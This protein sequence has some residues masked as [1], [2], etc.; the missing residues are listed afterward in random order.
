[1]TKK[2]FTG[3]SCLH[4]VLDTNILYDEGAGDE[5]FS[6]A[7]TKVISNEAYKGLNIRWT[8]P[9]MVQ[10]ER[11]YHLRE[12]AKHIIA[13]ANK[14]LPSVLSG[15]WVCDAE[16]V[17]A[18]IASH[19]QSAIEK[20]GVTVRDCDPSKVDWMRIME[21]S[22][23]RLPPFDP[24]AEAEKG[25]KDAVVAETFMQICEEMR[26]FVH[27][28]AILLTKD[29]LLAQHIEERVSPPRSKVLRNIGA[30]T[31]ELNFLVADIDADYA[32]VLL[33]LAEETVYKSAD[34]WREV[35]A[36]V[37]QKLA[38]PP[39]VLG[40]VDVKILD[41]QYQPNIF[42]RKDMHAVYFSCRLIYPRTGKVWLVDYPQTARL[43][44]LGGTGV[45]TEQGGT[46]SAYSPAIVY[47]TPIDWQPPL[48]TEP[49]QPTV[50]YQPYST[51]FVP[52]SDVAMPYLGGTPSY[53]GH[54]EE[55]Q[56]LPLSFIVEWSAT[57]YVETID[58][59]KVPK[60]GSPNLVQIVTA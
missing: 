53:P 42:L 56:I 58:G 54:Y 39:S 20:L 31:S 52:Q 24:N 28:S 12:K 46:D 41:G 47:P 16:K 51:G 5:F 4:V 55:I 37:A 10:L 26:P 49:M 50:Q 8:I 45:Q 48:P 3:M 27:D 6:P 14:D 35:I 59:V 60:L 13:A 19:A 32:K 17:H 36:E 25:F 15:N 30:L 44:S 18:K 1:M 29:K 34:F 43:Y 23:L 21:S 11:E 38:Q 57:Y 2:L 33:Q 9:R 22:G 40:F 7:I